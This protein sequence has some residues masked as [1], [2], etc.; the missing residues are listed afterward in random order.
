MEQDVTDSRINTI[1]ATFHDLSE[2]PEYMVN[3]TDEFIAQVDK[4]MDDY[5]YA[6]T[7]EDNKIIYSKGPGTNLKFV[8]KKIEIKVISESSKTLTIKFYY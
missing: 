2:L 8:V 1:K 3:T 7:E 5:R 4:V 6:R